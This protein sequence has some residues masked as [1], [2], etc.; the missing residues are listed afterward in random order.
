MLHTRED[1]IRRAHSR[2]TLARSE[3]TGSNLGGARLHALRD[4]FVPIGGNLFH[5]VSGSCHAVVPRD[6]YFSDVVTA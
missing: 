6:F 4:V 5:A 3:G 1:R 2:K